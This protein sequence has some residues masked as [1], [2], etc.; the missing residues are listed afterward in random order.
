MTSRRKTPYQLRVPDESA[1]LVRNL[2]PQLKRKVKAGLQHLLS[3]P[4]VGNSLKEDL[5]GLRSYRVGRFRIIY[6]IAAKKIIE[7]IAIG[8]RKTIYEETYIAVKKESKKK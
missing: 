8:P 6:R 2:H 3:N 1:D 4:N 5:E 7:L